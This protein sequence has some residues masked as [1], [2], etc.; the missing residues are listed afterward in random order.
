MTKDC[1]TC[2]WSTWK[3]H[4]CCDDCAQTNWIPPDKGNQD[5]QTCGRDYDPTDDVCATCEPTGWT[6]KEETCSE[7]S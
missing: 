1:T 5:C 4:P 2:E 6:P 7:P 3:D